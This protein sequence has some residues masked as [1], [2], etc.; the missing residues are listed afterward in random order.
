M[1]GKLG[2][3]YGWNADIRLGL[4]C[5]VANVCFWPFSAVHHTVLLVIR[6]TAFAH[7]AAGEISLAEFSLRVSA[8]HPIAAVEVVEF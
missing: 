6:M 3:R 2:I 7:K 8:L 1:S 5:R 4:D